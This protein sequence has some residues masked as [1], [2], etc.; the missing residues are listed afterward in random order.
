[1]RDGRDGKT[2]E[3]A[4]WGANWPKALLATKI[5]RRTVD[6]HGHD[7]A[8]GDANRTLD[9]LLKRGYSSL[10]NLDE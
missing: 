3:T 2:S 6:Q 9:L 10:L 8:K 4:D 7:D 1:M 5:Y